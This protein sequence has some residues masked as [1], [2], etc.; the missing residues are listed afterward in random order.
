MDGGDPKLVSL[1][2]GASETVM[3]DVFAAFRVGLPAPT[4]RPCMSRWSRTEALLALADIAPN[5]TIAR[6]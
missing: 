2:G 1:S 6:G 4:W 5:T 3:G